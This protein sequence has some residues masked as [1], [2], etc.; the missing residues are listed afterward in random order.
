MK[1]VAYLSC[2]AGRKHFPQTNISVSIVDKIHLDI[3]MQVSINNMVLYQ[4][5]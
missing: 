4:N 2:S 5:T 3:T 1:I